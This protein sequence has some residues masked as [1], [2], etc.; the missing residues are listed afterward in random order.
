M[1]KAVIAILFLAAA[2]LSAGTYVS[3]KG[4]FYFEYPENWIQVDFNT[5]DLFLSRSVTDLSSMEY[6]AIFA[7]A[8]SSPFFAGEYLILKL[9]TLE[10]LYEY[11]EDSIIEAVEADIGQKLLNTSVWDQLAD[12]NSFISVYDKENKIIFIQSDITQGV[13]ILKRSIFIKKMYDKGVAEFYFFA[14]HETFESSK[15]IFK[16]IVSSFSTE[17]VEQ[18]LPTEKLKVADLDDDANISSTIMITAAAALLIIIA[19]IV[20]LKMAA[21]RKEE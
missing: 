12:T 3:F 6:E 7:L 10:W 21:R 5:A 13:Q 4:G 1:K 18:A 17:N 16:N 9:D 14:P 2:N 19:I 20:R 15:E 8:E 11:K